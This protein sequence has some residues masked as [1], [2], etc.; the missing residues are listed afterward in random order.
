M[1]P[2][3][4]GLHACSDRPIVAAR[5][6][7]LT[8]T[9]T[10]GGAPAA[11]QEV[12]VAQTAHAFAFGSNGF[13]LVP[14]ASGKLAGA[15][16][17]RTEAY[18][19][20]LLE[21]CNSVTLPFYWQGYEP[22]RGRPAVERLQTAARWC[23]E[24]GLR[25]KGHP[26]CW[27]TLSPDWL[28]A[29]DDDA[30]L[31]ALLGRIKREGEAFRGLVDSWDVVN[32]AVIM[33]VFDK[34]PNALTRLANRH[35]RI[36]LLRKAFAAARAADPAAV[37]FI[38]DFD[39]TSPYEILIEGCLES[40]IKIDAIGIQSHMHQGYWGEAKTLAILER[41]ERF[42]LPIQF[43]ETTIISGDLMPPE[44]VDLNDFKVESWPTTPEGEARQADEAVRHYKTLAARPLVTGIT[45]WD[46]DD[47]NWLKA[48]SGLLRADASA[49]PAYLELLKLVKGEWWAKPA[50]LKADAAGVLRFNA[51]AGDYELTAGGR[52][53]A[54]RIEGAG[55]RQAALAL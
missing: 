11:G 38:N 22:V 6:A 34:Y 37:L 9:L 29:L 25:V 18:A 27:H 51:F 52:K 53:Y 48:P 35:G 4:T 2:S 14:L 42:G 20:R 23:R 50:T 43:T 47:G 55:E 28:T 41:Y 17:D 54:F 5:A 49:K 1:N 45:W 8:L 39:Y 15:V 21:L 16:L 46:L 26:L 30:A 44:I 7:D 40:G 3:F 24:R 36:G 33:P 31:E 32:E 12:V 10:R 19:A 13:P